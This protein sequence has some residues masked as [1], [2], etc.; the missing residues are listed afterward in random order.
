MKILIREK[1]A[2]DLEGI[3]H[4][5]AKDNPS[6]AAEVVRRIRRRIGRLA[7]S[8]L[9]HIGRPGLIAGT[10]ELVEVPYIIVYEVH[11]DREEIVVLAVFHGAQSR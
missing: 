2:G 7:V 4:W 9:A 8:G 3:F 5:I 1:A 6:A 10:R 11:D